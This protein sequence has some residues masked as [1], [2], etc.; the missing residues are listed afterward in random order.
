MMIRRGKTHDYQ[1]L[2]SILTASANRIKAKGSTQWSHIL[3]GGEDETLLNRLEENNVWL[4]EDSDRIQGMLYL[5][6]DLTDWDKTLWEDTAHTGTY[7]L[8][9]LALHDK[10]TGKG[11]PKL[12]FEG[13]VGEL[14]PKSVRLDCMATKQVLNQLYQSLGF[15]LVATK[16]IYEESAKEMVTF[17]LYEWQDK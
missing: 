5:Y 1:A 13:I 2:H 6:E 16:D 7:Y 11:I 12:L 15:T 10:D 4:I 17:N 3:T 9:K 8:H 14:Q